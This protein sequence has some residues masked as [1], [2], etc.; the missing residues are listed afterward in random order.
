MQCI[1]PH[2]RLT[3]TLDSTHF[4]ATTTSYLLET[5]DGGL[6]YE[7]L[8][9]FS[10]ATSATASDPWA[11]GALLALGSGT[12]TLWGGGACRVWALGSVVCERWMT[13][14]PPRRITPCQRGRYYA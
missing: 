10:W 12:P 2:D 3:I 6:G 9:V 8:L 5:R 4:H 1:R 14:C 13:V 7:S 11:S